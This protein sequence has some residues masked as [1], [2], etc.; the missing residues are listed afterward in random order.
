M[1]IYYLILSDDRKVRVE[2]N[3]NSME[4]FRSIT[5][6]ELT[7]LAV[8][9]ADIPTLRTIAWCSIREGE[10]IEGR[11]FEL[12]EKGLGRLMGMKEIVKFSEILAEQSNPGEQKKTKPPRR[13]PLI[14]FRRKG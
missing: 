9:K 12:D 4:E 14:H 6:M 10:E 11:D 7:D 1:K 13:F 2:W 8:K 3:M 5:G